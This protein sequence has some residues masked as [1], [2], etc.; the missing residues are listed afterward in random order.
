MIDHEIAA[1]IEREWGVSRETFRGYESYF[2]GKIK[3]IIKTNYLSHLVTTVEN[4]VN[5]SGVRKV[6]VA[7]ADKE[8]K[9]GRD[10]LKGHLSSRTF[11]L[12]SIVL[13]PAKIK[14][15]ATTRHHHCGAIIYYNSGYDEKAIR[16]LIAHEI[17]HIVNRELLQKDDT[18]R[19][20][21]LF[22]YIALHDKNAFYKDESGKYISSDVQIF[23]DIANVCRRPGN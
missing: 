7:L 20:A 22:A 18:E 16:I 23:N 17:G 14:K 19:A 8:P 21:N 12:Y 10:W 15:R 4:M 9:S 1:K 2:A 13:V 3:P 11:R 6:L 5:E